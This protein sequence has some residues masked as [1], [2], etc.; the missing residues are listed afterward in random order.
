MREREDGGGNIQL[1]FNQ[2]VLF[3]TRLGLIDIYIYDRALFL[4]VVILLPFSPLL[5]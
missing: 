1:G 2:F 3:L 4:G 5:L